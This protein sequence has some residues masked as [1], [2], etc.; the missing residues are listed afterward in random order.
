M[1]AV[2]YY[3]SLAHDYPILHTL[4]ARRVVPR[5]V[6]QGCIHLEI[7]MDC[8]FIK[9]CS[10]FCLATLVVATG[11]GLLGGGIVAVA[12]V[13]VAAVCVFVLELE[14]VAIVVDALPSGRP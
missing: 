10:L 7:A 6:S 4:R 3:C 5:L 12:G 2:E 8:T 1:C 11:T 13:F 14:L 9:A